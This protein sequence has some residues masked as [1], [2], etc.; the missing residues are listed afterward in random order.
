MSR[1]VLGLIRPPTHWIPG[2]FPR[3]KELGYDVTTY[4]HLVPRLRI[5]GSVPLL[6]YLFGGVRRFDDCGYSLVIVNSD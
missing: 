4:H 1:P 2:F 3:A 5:I 6:P